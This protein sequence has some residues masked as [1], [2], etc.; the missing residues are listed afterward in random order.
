MKFEFRKSKKP[1]KKYDAVFADIP[2]NQHLRGRVVSFGDS[3][4]QQYRDSTPLRA[5]S[6]LDHGDKKRRDAYF[7]RHARDLSVP[8]SAGWF[9]ARYLW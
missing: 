1:N 7:A 3:R 2:E 8:Y 5:Y 9:A 6:H 4:Y